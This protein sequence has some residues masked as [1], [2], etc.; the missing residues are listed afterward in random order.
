MAVLLF[1]DKSLFT[2][3]TINRQSLKH[4]V[5]QSAAIVANAL[6]STAKFTPFALCQ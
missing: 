2:M 3:N 4:D 5:S 1:K 6:L